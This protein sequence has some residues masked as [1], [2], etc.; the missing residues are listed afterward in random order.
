M[1]IFGFAGWSGSGKTTLVKAVIPA[2]LARG[3]TVSTIKHTHH[4]FDMDKPGKDS[5][6]HRAAGAHE[7]VIS[8]AT[9]WAL[10]HE[11]RGEPELDIAGMLERMA[12]VDL[13]LI[14]GFKSYPHPKMEVHRPEV[15]KSLL[16]VDDPSIVAV[17]T[18]QSLDVRIPQLSLDDPEAVTD[19]VV[20]YLGLTRERSYGP[21]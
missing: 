3:L 15:G 9:R 17:A 2:L 4:N 1:K 12:P 10:L 13:V 11:N 6:E 7:V 21:A 8:S 20:T 16:C 5:F 14:E 19:F 18:T